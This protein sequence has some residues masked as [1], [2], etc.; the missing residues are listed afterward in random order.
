MRIL[1][2]GNGR[3]GS[4][5]CRGVQ[6]GKA[7]GSVIVKARAFEIM[8]HDV[9]V[10]VKR[11]A[12]SELAQIRRAGVPWIWDLVDF[13]PQPAAGKWSDK[14]AISW[15]RN[16]I[17]AFKPNGI[18]YPTDRMRTD[19]GIDGITVYHHGRT[20]TPVNQ[21]REEIRTVGY[22]GSE[23]Y[24]GAWGN[25]ARRI[26]ARYGW[27]FVVNQP[28]NKMD[29]VLAVRDKIHAGYAQRH[30]KSNVKLANAHVTGTP[31][32]GQRESGY[33]ETRAGGE[34]WVESPEDLERVLVSLKSFQK[35]KQI[36]RDFRA[37][38]ITV[39]DC[40]KQVQEYAAAICA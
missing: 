35:R 39:E 14:F 21:I 36:S 27:R 6:L 28:L 12:A 22:E 34:A 26:C 15:V 7:S 4:W 10:A 2:T 33:D 30:W 38:A 20:D 25:E 9:V 1:T 17:R 3:S 19:I 23:K 18:I 32:V 5:Q 8:Q 29:V 11:L 24:L 13:Y 31:F 37:N 40:A 16:S